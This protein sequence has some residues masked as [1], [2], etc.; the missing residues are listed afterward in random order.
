[1]AAV[2][3]VLVAC[4]DDDPAPEVI[5]GFSYLVD[6]A[7]YRKVTFTNASQNFET[8]SWD[9][10]DSSPLSAEENPVH[11]YAAEGTYT[12]TL[13][14]ARGNETDEISLRK[15]ESCGRSLA[16]RF[17]GSFSAVCGRSYRGLSRVV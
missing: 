8:L 6:P 15:R 14:A 12:V 4:D 1:M 10:G 17:A 2:L 7:D 9:F 3:S 13:V 11:T 5:A 16:L